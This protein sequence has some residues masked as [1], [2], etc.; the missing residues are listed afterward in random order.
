[1]SI[2]YEKIQQG[3][4]REWKELLSPEERAR[5]RKEEEAKAPPDQKKPKSWLRLRDEQ[6]EARLESD[7]A[8]WTAAKRKVQR[9]MI[10]VVVVIGAFMIAMMIWM[11]VARQRMTD[12]FETL[13]PLLKRGQ[14]YQVYG[15]P[16]DAWAS[17]RS[18]LMRGD[19]RAL[20]RVESA[21]RQQRNRGQRAATAYIAQLDDMLKRGRMVN[22]RH[23]ATLFSS[24]TLLTMPD[25]PWGEGELAVLA[26]RPL[27][28]APQQTNPPRGARNRTPQPAQRPPAT[29]P[30]TRPATPT[31]TDA[32]TTVWV[33]ALSYNREAREWRFED[34]R[35]QKH[36]DPSWTYAAQIRPVIEMEKRARNKIAEQS[37][38]D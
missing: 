29:T 5:R 17:W 7:K 27:P 12:K 25:S 19:G 38:L 22:E 13:E 37:G 11:S 35:T 16:A 30:T 14:T 1:M 3:R 21:A 8:Q 10:A 18:A 33:L 28:P 4:R 9:I 23:V 2:D 31:P 24:P 20:A 32:K 36:W 26:S 34:L 6:L 15:D